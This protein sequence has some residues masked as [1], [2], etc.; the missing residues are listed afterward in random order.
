MMTTHHI[1]NVDKIRSGE[2]KIFHIQLTRMSTVHDGA[3][4]CMIFLMTRTLFL[5]VHVIAL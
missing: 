1:S 4:S 2:C 5:L 3:I